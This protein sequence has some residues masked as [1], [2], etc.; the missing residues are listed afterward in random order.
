[1]RFS[2]VDYFFSAQ[3]LP[4]A[5]LL[6]LASGAAP[7]AQ[8]PAEQQLGVE[9]AACALVPLGAELQAARRNMPM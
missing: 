7:S 1:M 8:P 4:A 2:A 5:A 6:S 3:Q 9:V